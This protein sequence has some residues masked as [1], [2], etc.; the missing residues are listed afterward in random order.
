[1]QPSHKIFLKS[2]RSAWRIGMK[3]CIANGASFAQLMAKNFDRVR[4]GHGAMMS[5]V[6]QPP[7][8]FSPKSHFQQCNLL[9]LTGM[10]TLCVIKV[11]T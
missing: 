9:P 3:F 4:S 10:E 5:Y 2:P 7:T 1:M 11:R 6:E 8:D